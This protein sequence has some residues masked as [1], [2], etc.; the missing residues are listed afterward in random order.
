MLGTENGLSYKCLTQTNIVFIKLKNVLSI[1][2]QVWFKKVKMHHQIKPTWPTLP[3]CFKAKPPLDTAAATFPSWSITTAPTVSN[4]SDSFSYTTEKQ[5]HW[6]DILK[7]WD[8]F[9]VEDIWELKAK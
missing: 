4:V 2:Q 7:Q 5:R 9:A 3:G 8:I 1:W 6:K